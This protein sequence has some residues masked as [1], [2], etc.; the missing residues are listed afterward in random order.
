MNASPFS[1]A[2]KVLAGGALAL[3]TF[4]VVGLFLPTA[5]QVEASRLVN[6]SPE[7]IF[8]YLDSPEGWRDWTTWPESGLERSGPSRGEGARIAWKD[9]DLGTG[10]FTITKAVP[11]ER[12]EYRVEVS[13]GTMYT[14]GAITLLTE[15]GGVRVTWRESGDLGNNPLMGYWGL[16][17]EPAQSEELAKG[18]ERLAELATAEPPP[19]AQPLDVH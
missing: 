6:A 18:L 12:I 3:A 10:S 11:Y 17:M 4:L 14:D 19:A 2:T 1:W 5:F 13:G 16:L 9:L 8:R 7:A 15:P